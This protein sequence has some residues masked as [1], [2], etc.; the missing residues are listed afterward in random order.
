[1]DLGRDEAVGLF[2]QTPLFAGLPEAAVA[3][4]AAGATLRRVRAGEWL[5]RQGDAGEHIYVVV[6]GRLE[7]IVESSRPEQV[8]RVHGRGELIGELAFIT[9]WARSASV[10]ARR[11]AELLEIPYTGF[12]DLVRR[13]TDVAVEILH[14]LARRL[15]TGTV[16]PAGSVPR[17]VAVVDLREREAVPVIGSLADAF[18]DRVATVSRADRR[19]AAEPGR[20]VDELERTH[21]TVVLATAVADPADWLNFCRRQADRVLCV[22]DVTDR[23]QPAGLALLAGCDLALTGQPSGRTASWLDALRPRAHHW[24]DLPNREAGVA[25]LVR[26]LLG[27][28]TGVVFSGGGARGFA[29]IGVLERLWE[30]GITVDRIGGCSMGAFVAAL[31]AMGLSAREMVDI[32]REE[33]V[34]RNP[35]NDYTLPRVSVIRARKAA[36]LMDR[37]FGATG[38]EN[39]ALD[40]FCVS[41]DLVSADLVVHRRGQLA[42]A[43]RP[44]S[45]LDLPPGFEADG[46]LLVDGGVLTTFQRRMATQL[47]KVPFGVDVMGRTR[48][49]QPG[50]RPT[51]V[52]TLAR[53]TVLG[54]WQ[55]LAA[56]AEQAQRVITPDVQAIG[57]RDFRRLDEAVAAGRRAVETAVEAGLLLS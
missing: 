17:T 54:S 27:R 21:D 14:V 9:G 15:A 47:A 25:R 43:W 19:P 33:F 3:Q 29:H 41:S 30:R 36:A 31:V 49:G 11:D 2:R 42:G 6:S 13:H 32:C 1:V 52:E 26:R 55:R 39:C 44:A 48:L 38:I 56:T 20:L 22:A 7:A 4:L 28:S 24:L 23:P 8:V 57:L 40:Y 35:F 12:R 53:A 10:R 45:I 16:T 51:L 37:V 46:R 50:T 34:R 5:F 18:G